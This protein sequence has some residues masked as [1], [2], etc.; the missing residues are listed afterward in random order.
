LCLFVILTFDVVLG[1]V[2]VVNPQP[3]GVLIARNAILALLLNLIM[4][5]LPLLIRLTQRLPSR[6][7]GKLRGAI[8]VPPV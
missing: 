1:L 3:T 7:I 8:M 4:H 6:L 5:L 2:K